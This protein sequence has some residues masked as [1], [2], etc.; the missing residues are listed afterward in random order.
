MLIL[1]GLLERQAPPARKAVARKQAARAAEPRRRWW[2]RPALCLLLAWWLR[3]TPLQANA[4]LNGMGLFL[5]L[6]LA[7]TIAERLA[8]GD[9]GWSIVSSGLALAGSLQVAGVSPHWVWLAAV[10]TAA[11]LT[12]LG[13]AEAMPVLLGR[14]DDH[15]CRGFGGVP[16]EDDS[17]RRTSPA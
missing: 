4:I 16:T 10:P 8:R 9:R 7:W 11:A 2:Q 15:R 13:V 1:A 12:L 17:C 6:L 14:D 3:G 5:G